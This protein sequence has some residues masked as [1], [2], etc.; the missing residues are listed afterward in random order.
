MLWTRGRRSARRQRPAAPARQCRPALEGLEERSL[1]SGNNFLQTNLVS[2]VPG[3]AQQFDPNLVNPWG[4]SQAPGGPFWVSDNGTGLSTLYDTNG[5]P[6][7]LIV[8]IPPPA[9]SPDGT[10]ATPTGQVFVGDL[11]SF[12]VSQTVDG[13]TTSGNSVFIF[14]TEDGTISA[15]SP[16]VDGTHA[17]LEVDNSAKP[18]ADRGAVY[19]GLAVGTDARGNPLL[20]AANFRAGTIDVY[21]SNFEHVLLDGRF[22]DPQ[23]PKGFAP[24]NIKELNGKLYV[25]YAK[26]NADKHDDVAGLGNGFVD[27]FSNDGVL[28]QHLAAGGVLNSPWGLVI[29]PQDFGKFGGA[30]LVGNF[31]DGL[32]HAFDPNTGQLLGTLKDADGE[33]IRIDGIWGL[34]VGTGGNG[35]DPNKVYFTAGIDGEAHGLFGSLEAT[36]ANPAEDF[37][38]DEVRALLRKDG[39]SLQFVTDLHSALQGAKDAN[40]Q[41]PPALSQLDDAAQAVLA[42]AQ[43]S[44]HQTVAELEALDALFADLVSF[45]KTSA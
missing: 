26:Q 28:E 8:T 35:G 33:A 19:K 12:R 31:G 5:V 22:R 7:S 15:W 13:T 25:T 45:I 36:P 11:G 41:L 9:G 2:D 43:D 6:Q 18:S 40:G 23:V 14:A 44:H 32:I 37:D 1:L 27:V 21:D 29:A 17:I 34:K 10:L 20:Y 24:F 16:A 3:L 42:A 30:L 4:I 38:A 39:V